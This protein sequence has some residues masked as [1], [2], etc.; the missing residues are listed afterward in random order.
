VCL[1]GV[2]GSRD[3]TAI[4][5]EGDHLREVGLVDMHRWDSDAVAPTASTFA[6]GL[7]LGHH[8]ECQQDVI[9]QR[10]AVRLQCDAVGCDRS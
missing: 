10:T 9:Q 7:G 4:R 6:F 2:C 1:Q 3:T 5:R 8:E